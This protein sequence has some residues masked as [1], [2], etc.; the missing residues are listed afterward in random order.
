M[1][2]FISEEDIIKDSDYP[3]AKIDLTLFQQA[4]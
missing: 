1:Q 3:A 4:H 2:D